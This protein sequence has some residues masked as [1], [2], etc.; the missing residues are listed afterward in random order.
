[1]ILIDALSGQSSEG[2][3]ITILF[4]LLKGIGVFVGMALI[5]LW[6]LRPLFHIVA[7]A[8]STELFMLA[9]LLVA[10]SAAAVTHHFEL[11]MA[12]GAFLAGLLLGETE[13]RHQIEIDIRPF[14]DVL[15]G[16]FFI[17]IGT[18][19]ELR[20]LPDNWQL[21]LITFAGII[22]IKFV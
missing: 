6:L 7:K 8:H 14:R 15:L 5:G 11:S 9:T 16:L 1:L 21:V 19:L 22:L 18:Y 10:L 13:F 4:T 3:G 2:L 17:I 20:T 12:L